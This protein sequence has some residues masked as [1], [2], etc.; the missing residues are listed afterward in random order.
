MLIKFPN[1]TFMVKTAGVST[2]LATNVLIIGSQK[3]LPHAT[4]IT[5]VRTT[6]LTVCYLILWSKLNQTAHQINN[7]RR[8]STQKK[9]LLCLSKFAVLPEFDDTLTA[10]N[11]LSSAR[12]CSQN[13]MLINPRSTASESTAASKGVRCQQ[14]GEWNIPSNVP[15]VLHSTLDL[16]VRQLNEQHFVILAVQAVLQCSRQEFQLVKQNLL[17]TKLF[18]WERWDKTILKWRLTLAYH[19]RDNVRNFCR[20]LR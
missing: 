19:D 7:A 3:P 15:T 8:R 18:Q 12:D 20:K 6:P 4:G 9:C 16:T 5:W 2:I 10:V 1:W 11:K 13:S 17:L 14:T